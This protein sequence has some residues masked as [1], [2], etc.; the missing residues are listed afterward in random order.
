MIAVTSMGALVGAIYAEG[1]DTDQ[2]RSMAVDL[3]SKRFY[4]M[5]EPALPKYGLICGRKIKDMLRAVIGDV[6][7]QDLE[8]PFACSATDIK[9]GHEV[10]VRQGLVREGVRASC[11]IPVIFTPTKIGGR[12]LVDGGLLNP[13]PVSI[14]KEIGSDFVI[15]VNVV[16]VG[17]GKLS[18]TSTGNTQPNEPNILNIAIQTVD[19]IS[20]QRLKS[21][22]VGADVI[23]E[24]T[25]TH[26]GQADFHRARECIFQGEVAT[27]ASMP[28]IK[29][30]LAG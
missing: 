15:A 3:G 11:S 9:R 7:F 27:Q 16:P 30:L 21:S 4:C 8:I 22:M 1:K 13:V 19:I 10:V 6:E 17:R 28:E 12:Y 23:I 18:E 20:C 29:R 24:P 5:A 2:M 25:V 26:I 14:L